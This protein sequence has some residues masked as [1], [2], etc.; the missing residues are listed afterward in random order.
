[1]IYQDIP[2][3]LTHQKL[4]RGRFAA[5]INHPHKKPEKMKKSVSV[6]LLLLWGSLAFSQAEW[7]FKTNVEKNEFSLFK[8]MIDDKYPITMYLEHTWDFCGYGTNNRWKARGLKGWYKYDRIG[9]KILLTGSRGS[10][11][12]EQF[13]KLYVPNNLLDTVHSVT[14]EM[15]DYK[16]KF[17]SMHTAQFSDLKWKTHQMDT[18]YTVNLKRIHPLS[19]GTKATIGFE[20]RGIEL[21]EINLNDLTEIDYIQNLEI[22]AKKEIDNN[23]Y[24]IM[25]FGHQS[26]IGSTGSGN[27]G[28]GYEGYLGFLTINSNL[29]IE[30]FEFHHNWSCL[31]SGIEGKFTFNKEHPEKG[32]FRND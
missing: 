13:I 22:L 8:G 27:C 7:G 20:V 25:E 11:D 31:K 5:I 2:V 1:M 29:K 23:F 15:E 10:S 9:T 4:E 28:M 19:Y 17:I 18:F 32:I 6:F 26:I 16:E 12:P 24:A 14:C 3:I 30:E 21:M